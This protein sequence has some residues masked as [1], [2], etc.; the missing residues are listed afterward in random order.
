MDKCP[1]LVVIRT[2]FSCLRFDLALWDTES[3]AS[4]VGLCRDC[5]L[6]ACV[7]IFSSLHWKL[8]DCQFDMR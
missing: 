3:L 6:G 7:A 1:G 4:S 8:T 2:L 5:V